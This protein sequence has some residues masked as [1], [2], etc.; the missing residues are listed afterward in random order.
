MNNN[1]V[2]L[3][4]KTVKILENGYKLGELCKKLAERISTPNNPIIID[5]SK[6]K[7]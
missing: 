2:E 4:A 1:L 7:N 3:D 6:L 5:L